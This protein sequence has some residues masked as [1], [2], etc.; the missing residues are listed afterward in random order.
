MRTCGLLHCVRES[1]QA[2]SSLKT[3]V[4]RQEVQ[5]RGWPRVSCIVPTCLDMYV[6][7]KIPR[8]TINST[9]RVVTSLLLHLNGS[10]VCDGI[11]G[12]EFNS[13]SI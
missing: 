6:Q 8:G 11:T 1:P 12:I 4:R 2:E 13:L 5:D 3:A 7:I 10:F 9:A